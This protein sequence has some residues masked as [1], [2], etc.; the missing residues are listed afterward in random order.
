MDTTLII[1]IVVVII[2]LV[3]L[4]LWYQTRQSPKKEDS[5]EIVEHSPALAESKPIAAPVEAVLDEPAVVE[6]V[7][8]EPVAVEPAIVEPAV[9]EPVMV[10]REDLKIIEGIGPKIESILNNAGILTFAQLA[11][12]DPVELKQILET[13]GLRLGDPTTWP[14]QAKLAAEGKTDEL[15][16]LQDQLKGGRRA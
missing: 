2:L 11:A 7:V 14:E 13:A 9:K 3:I 16:A 6:P 15:Q 8:D 12:N 10:E 5:H 1:F 4:L